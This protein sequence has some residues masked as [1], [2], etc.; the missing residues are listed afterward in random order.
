[1]VGAWEQGKARI[2]IGIP[3]TGWTSMEWAFGLRFLDLPERTVIHRQRGSPIDIARNN[4]A[5]AALDADAEWLMFID[6]DT[7]PP[8]DAIAKLMA[9]DAD[10]VSGLYYTRKDV[11]L[12]CAY[13]YI[14]GEA[15]QLG[16]FEKNE[17]C[18]V[19]LVGMGCC[20]IHTRVFKNL[21]KA[22]SY[23][24]FIVNY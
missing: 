2:V 23:R 15:C 4:L 10:I 3:H 24:L 1:M 19:D 21:P 13:K 12:P 11:I 17:V 18:E 22:S 20:L 9:H 16:T 14:N 7:V 8:P 5:Q 6:S